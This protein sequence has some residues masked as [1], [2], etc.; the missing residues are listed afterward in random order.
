M[1][2]TVE[3]LAGQDIRVLSDDALRAP[4][5]PPIGVWEVFDPDERFV[6]R[7][8]FKAEESGI[9][10]VDLRQKTQ[11]IIVNTL[12]QT[13]S[14]IRKKLREDP[15]VRLLNRNSPRTPGIYCFVRPEPTE[16]VTQVVALSPPS[17]EETRRKENPCGFVNEEMALHEFLIRLGATQN[18]QIP[19][20][21]LARFLSLESNEFNGVLRSYRAKLNQSPQSDRALMINPPT[22]HSGPRCYFISKRARDNAAAPP[23]T[24]PQRLIAIPPENA[25]PTSIIQLQQD[26]PSPTPIQEVVSPAQPT[27]IVTAP[28]TVVVPAPSSEQQVFPALSDEQPAMAKEPQSGP[29]IPVTKPERQVL[30]LALKGFSETEIAT[31]LE[32]SRSGVSARLTRFTRRLG[33]KNREDFLRFC[34]ENHHRMVVV[35][36][37]EGASRQKPAAHQRPRLFP[38][39]KPSS[40]AREP[41]RG[42]PAIPAR[43]AGTYAI[44][45]RPVRAVKIPLMPGHRRVPD[46]AIA[47]PLEPRDPLDPLHPT[48][49]LFATHLV[50]HELWNTLRQVDKDPQ[51]ALRQAAPEKDVILARLARERTKEQVDSTVVYC[52]VRAIA[53]ALNSLSNK[54]QTPEEN[55]LL[56]HVVGLKSYG[57]EPIA[58]DLY[59][60]FFDRPLP[61]NYLIGISTN[62][63]SRS[64]KKDDLP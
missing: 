4:E 17:P 5:H 51:T 7:L 49:I 18:N 36:F 50:Q 56:V 13:L 21:E 63:T 3:R 10:S 11:G 29:D 53:W 37:P 45:P 8:I 2:A 9:S 43:T 52:V 39:S 12:P 61:D 1:V 40:L 24:L 16:P 62:T 22:L 14:N 44:P 19:L 54:A 42:L 20:Q 15:S 6:A 46:A 35:S 55:H 28:L 64:R 41:R 57:I 25:I 30:E 48:W 26:V 31:R 27:E 47:E 32:M 60:H 38:R 34:Q 59:L 58:T 33:I 23:H